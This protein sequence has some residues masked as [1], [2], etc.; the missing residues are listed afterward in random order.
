MIL[1][2]ALITSVYKIIN[3]IVKKMNF[4]GLNLK[5]VEKITWKYMTNNNNQRIRDVIKIES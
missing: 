3:S 2:Q 1:L 5:L 4:T